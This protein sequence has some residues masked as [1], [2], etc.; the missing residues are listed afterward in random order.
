MPSSDGVGLEPRRAEGAQ[1]PPNWTGRQ[2]A[3][4]FL[5]TPQPTAVRSLGEGREF[6]LWQKHFGWQEGGATDSLT[7]EGPGALTVPLEEF[8]P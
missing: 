1:M 6:S 5:P 4:A 8:P 3:T 2:G 7:R